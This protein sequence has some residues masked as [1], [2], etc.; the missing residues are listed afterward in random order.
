MS[1]GTPGV[2]SELRNRHGERL[3]FTLHPGPLR[4][5]VVLA[6]GVT[7][8]K[9]RPWLS[10]LAEALAAA[11]IAA[12]RFS[13]AGNGGSEG[14]FEDA[15]LTKEVEDLGSVIDNLIAAGFE[16]IVCAGHSM[17]GAICLL[18]A[19]RDPRI[20]ALVSL[21]GMVHVRQ[22]MQAQF[23]HLQPGRDL[24]LGKPGCTWTSALADDAARIG[25]LT[26][27][28]AG[29]RIPWLLVHGTS[30]E[31]VPLADSLDARAAA[32]GRPE[33]VELEG[34]DHRFTGA[35]PQLVA[36]VVPWIRRQLSA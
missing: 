10:E 20:R 8:H 35:I 7:S 3:D 19:A 28:A 31:L 11:G 14:R 15:T 16:R 30:D 5:V 12:V 36:A 9:D 32:G 6:H 13:F 29:I 26:Q 23:S 33:L 4:N 25:S 22:F 17:G 1:G 2:P 24:M 21:A 34:A 27:L 18:R